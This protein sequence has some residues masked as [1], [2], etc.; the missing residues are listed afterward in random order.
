MKKMSV[1]GS[2]GS[3]GKNVLE[4][5]KHLKEYV[6]IE[7]LA[8]KS[9]IDLLEAQA[10][11]FSPKLLAV[12]D[13]E[14]ALQLQKRL[15]HIPVI[16]GM[17]GL[18][19]VATF[20]SVNFVVSAIV[21]AMGILPTLRAIESGK[22]IG[23]ANKEVLV[24]AGEL[25]MKAAKKHRVSIFPIDSEH[26]A[27][28]QCLNGEK[29]ETVR[30]LILTASGGSF[31]N[32]SVEEMQRITPEKALIHPNWNMGP[33]ITV[34]S[35]TL[36]NKGL[37]VI[38]AHYLFDI[39]LSQIQ[40]VVH[41]QSLV[42]SFVE[43]IDGSL[44]AQIGEPDMKGP[45]QYAITYPDRKKGIVPPFD[46]SKQARL[47]FFD[48]DKEKFP[49]LNLALKAGKIGGTLPC[50]MNAAN[51]T[52]VSRFLKGEI[53]FCEIGKRLERVMEKHTVLDANNLETLFAV[54]LAAR[55]LCAT[56]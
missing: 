41:P 15:P 37:E 44:M 23:L 10:K 3:I 33:K 38:E 19:N 12:Y 55:E 47:E 20:D 46:F 34:D 2:T 24:A 32:F 42:H 1:L 27:I 30:K 22:T 21:G 54:D 31:L 6:S 36:M 56:I 5:A 7:A 48:P 51:E 49:C 13:K 53:G 45:I 4:V 39:P 40:V 35:S 50:F 29:K 11:Q 18:L 26:S 8:A 25:I 16:G 14:K 43:F 28:F 52:F 9:N 17:D